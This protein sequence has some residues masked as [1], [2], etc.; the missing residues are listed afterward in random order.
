M[1][2]GSEMA[3]LSL[4]QQAN[5]IAAIM[6]DVF[7]EQLAPVTSQFV[8]KPKPLKIR[9]GSGQ[10]TY[11]RAEPRHDTVVIGRKMV[12]SKLSGN[13]SAWLSSREILRFQ[14]FGGELSLLNSLAHTLCHEFAHLIQIN[15]H[16]RRYGSVHNHE[17]YDILHRLHL[18]GYANQVK[19]SL[20]Q[21]LLAKQ[22]PLV[23]AETPSAPVQ[24]PKLRK[25]QTIRFNHNGLATE[26]IVIRLNTKTVSAKPKNASGRLAYWRIPYSLIESN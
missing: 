15:L 3:A 24:K 22:L 5:D 8:T 20:Q 7:C 1:A 25:G 21:R 6:V 19:A 4:S 12:L 14:L 2:G 11:Y 18:L 9:V 17:F 13:L 26:A 23:V 16:G 10:A